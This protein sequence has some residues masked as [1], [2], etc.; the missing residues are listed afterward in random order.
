MVHSQWEEEEEENAPYTGYPRSVFHSMGIEYPSSQIASTPHHPDRAHSPSLITTLGMIGDHLPITSHLNS[1]SRHDLTSTPHLNSYR[2]CVPGNPTHFPPLL[3]MGCD[4]FTPHPSPEHERACTHAR[5]RVPAPR[6]REKQ[7]SS[8]DGLMCLGLVV[9][10][11][12]RGD[13]P[14]E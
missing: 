14:I 12:P 7:P 11:L 9:F 2:P 4:T 5:T 10:S 8:P 6:G 3:E 1:S 13:W